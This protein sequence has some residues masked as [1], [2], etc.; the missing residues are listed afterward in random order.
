MVDSSKGVSNARQTHFAASYSGSSQ[1]K[2][3]VA[4]ELLRLR[5][6]TGVLQRKCQTRTQQ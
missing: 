1:M 6:G 2:R 5:E 3:G 4:Q